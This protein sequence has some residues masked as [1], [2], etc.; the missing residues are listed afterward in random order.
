M[1]AVFE[2]F[3]GHHIEQRLHRPSLGKISTDYGVRKKLPKMITVQKS[4]SMNL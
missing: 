4:S 3:L 2:D 1:T